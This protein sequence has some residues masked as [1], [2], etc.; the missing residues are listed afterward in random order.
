MTDKTGGPAMPESLKQAQPLMGARDRNETPERLVFPR[1]MDLRD[2]F[3]A[4]AMQGMLAEG[5]LCS[6]GSKDSVDA[7]ADVSYAY[8]DAML[9]AREAGDGNA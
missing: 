5:T 6:S 3:A 1:Q 9:K 2:Y 7:M 8:A 4:R